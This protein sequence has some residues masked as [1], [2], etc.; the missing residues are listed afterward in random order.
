MSLPFSHPGM[1]YLMSLAVMQ[2][3]FCLSVTA[4]TIANDKMNI[5]YVGV[6][7][8]LS[9]S[10]FDYKCEEITL[11]TKDGMLNK[12]GCGKIYDQA[13]RKRRR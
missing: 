10:V 11:A 6:D 7:N 3:Q 13:D 2:F 4:Q 9:I 1:K 8:P 12:T 5:L